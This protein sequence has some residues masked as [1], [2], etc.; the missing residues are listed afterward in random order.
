M[1]RKIPSG[2]EGTVRSLPNGRKARGLTVLDPCLDNTGEDVLSE[3]GAVQSP[4]DREKTEIKSK[5]ASCFLWQME[6]N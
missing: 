6:I 1:S 4:D 5:K 3:N 2:A